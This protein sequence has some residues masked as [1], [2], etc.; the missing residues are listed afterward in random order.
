MHVTIY[1]Q[2]PVKNHYSVSEVM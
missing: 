2:R 1:Q